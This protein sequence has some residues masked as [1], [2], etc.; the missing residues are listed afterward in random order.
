[1]DKLSFSNDPSGLFTNRADDIQLQT[2]NLQPPLKFTG[3]RPNSF[4]SLVLY[5]IVITTFLWLMIMALLIADY[6]EMFAGIKYNNHNLLFVNHDNLSR[7]FIFIW[8]II[9]I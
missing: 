2:M 3:F 4:G 1:M 8:V 7:V 6:Y 9:C 5:S